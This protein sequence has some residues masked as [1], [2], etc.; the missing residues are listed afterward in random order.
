MI[1][2]WLAGAGAVVGGAAGSLA[3]AGQSYF[4]DALRPLAR[5]VRAGD[6]E[7]SEAAGY[8]WGVSYRFLLWYALPFSMVTGTVVSHLVFLPADVIGLRSPARW[9]SAAVTAALGAA[10]FVGVDLL[11]QLLDEL[12]IAIAE[13]VSTLTDPVLWLYPAI[14]LV[15]ALKVARP[16]STAGVVLAAGGSAA[17]IFA[18]AGSDGGAAAG[19]A[20]IGLVALFAIQLLRGR[21]RERPRL[22][23][24]AASDTHVRAGL[25][26]LLVVAGG[27]A[28]LAEAHLIAGDPMTALLIAEGHEV[29]AAAVALLSF[30]AFFPLAIVSGMTADS[31][32]TQGTPDWIPGVGYVSP[33]PWVALFAGPILMAA[34]VL[35]AKRS[36]RVVLGSP[37]IS[38]TAAAVREAIGDVL[39]VSLMFGGLL[40]AEQLAGPLGFLAVGVA[41]LANENL[42][43]PIM[44]FAVAPVG[45]II[46]G[47]AANLWEVLT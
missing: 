35:T 27:V 38:E 39:L 18:L 2:P 12:P 21:G 25:P 30:A 5:D 24:L 14:P 10:V 43:K 13:K 32:S 1:D 31:Y 45:A 41:W 47:G 28:V 46:V 33:A 6:V 26:L 19:G 36:F 29:D 34:E 42:G 16:L 11:P 20:L 37:V 8:G 22:P 7:R 44:R 15:G 4:H 9:A 3:S 40:M 23:D 17:A